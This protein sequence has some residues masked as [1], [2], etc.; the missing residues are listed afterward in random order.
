MRKK[1]VMK[2]C[3]IEGCTKEV[4]AKGKSFYNDACMNRVKSMFNKDAKFS[5]YLNLYEEIHNDTYKWNKH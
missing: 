2:E 1:K 4:K 3:R 5:E